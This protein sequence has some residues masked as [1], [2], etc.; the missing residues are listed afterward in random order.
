MICEIIDDLFDKRFLHN[1]FSVVENLPYAANNTANRKS[2][3]YGEKAAHKLMGLPIFE[4]SSLNRINVLHHQSASQFFDIFEAISDYKQQ[5]YYLNR[6]HLNMQ[7]SGCDGTLHVDTFSDNIDITIMIMLNP[8][9][10]KHWGGQFQLFAEDRKK[11]LEEVDYVPGR[12][13]LFPGHYPHR[14]LGAHKDYPYVYRYTTV[15]R[16]NPIQT[17]NT[18]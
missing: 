7:H 8:E 15:F 14:G 18:K 5:E 17:E 13:V 10:K 4:R 6:I 9:W 3:P 12:V 16:V 2:W 1:F 11:L